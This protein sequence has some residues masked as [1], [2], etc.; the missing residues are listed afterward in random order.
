MESKLVFRPNNKM[1][2]SLDLLLH[3][4]LSYLTW[5]HNI[6]LS[7]FLHPQAAVYLKKQ[8]DQKAVNPGLTH[9][10][11]MHESQIL[12]SPLVSSW[13]NSKFLK[14]FQLSASSSVKWA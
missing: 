3:D 5:A 11:K 12:D 8:T 10:I 6:I 14:N 1:C 7:L 2:V 9:L 4:G 13:S